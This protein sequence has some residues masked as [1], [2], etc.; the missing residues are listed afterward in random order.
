MGTRILTEKEFG[1]IVRG[2]KAHGKTQQIQ[3][4]TQK[5]KQKQKQKQNQTT[6]NKHKHK[7]KQHTVPNLKHLTQGMVMGQRE[8]IVCRLPS[9]TR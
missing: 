5:Q 7:Q 1:E 3:T 8:E 4:Q 9:S 6:N 2:W